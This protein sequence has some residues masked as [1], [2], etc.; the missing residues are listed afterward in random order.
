MSKKFKNMFCRYDFQASLLMNAYPTSQL[1]LL[2][3]APQLVF[4]YFSKILIILV[5]KFAW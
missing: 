5:F 1:D 2:G 4:I 3:R